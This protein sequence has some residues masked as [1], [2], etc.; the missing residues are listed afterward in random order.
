MVSV[1]GENVL[2][3]GILRCINDG[4]AEECLVA[5]AIVS[6]AWIRSTTT[7]QEKRETLARCKVIASRPQL[8]EWRSREPMS[9]LQAPVSLLIRMPL[10]PHGV[11]TENHD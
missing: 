8:G 5:I 11:D 6:R 4:F 10:L 2:R 7:V 1:S 9:Q 3:Q